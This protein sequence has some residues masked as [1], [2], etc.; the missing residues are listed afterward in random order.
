MKTKL[1]NGA[2]TPQ[3]IYEELRKTCRLVAV[4]ENNGFIYHYYANKDLTPLVMEV[5]IYND[6]AIATRQLSPDAIR[7]IMPDYKVV[8]NDFTFGGF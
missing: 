5:V 3:V 6:K 1:S 2:R 7:L 8:S 4:T